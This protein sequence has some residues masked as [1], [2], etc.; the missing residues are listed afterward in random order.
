MAMQCE[1]WR[2][3]VERSSIALEF[4]ALHSELKYSCHR[5]VYVGATKR[6]HLTG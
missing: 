5:L 1:A 3:T 6:R 2:F 4:V